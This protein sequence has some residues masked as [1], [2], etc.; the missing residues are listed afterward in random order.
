MAIAHDELV[1]HLLADRAKLLAYIWVIV[2]DEHAAEDV[3][4][5]VSMLALYKRD[6]IRDADHLMQWLRAVARNKS[7]H[8]LRDRRTAP[9]PLDDDVVEMMTPHFARHDQLDNLDVIDAIKHCK[10]KLTPNAQQII[11]ARYRDG[12][13]GAALAD[14]FQRSV[15]TVY[16]ALTRAHRALAE[17]IRMRMEARRA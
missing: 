1:R 17:C 5:D 6:E 7:L 15:N 4:Q 13:T 8:L 16:Q 11:E 14:R 10:S 12:L 9:G 3:F 2:R